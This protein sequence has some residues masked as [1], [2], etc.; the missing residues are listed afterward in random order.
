MVGLLIL[1]E[2]ERERESTG[3]RDWGVERLLSSD[4]GNNERER[5]RE[6]MGGLDRGKLREK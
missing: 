5:E 2:R 1:V 3:Q 6:W 4:W